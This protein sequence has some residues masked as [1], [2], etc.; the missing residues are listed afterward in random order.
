VKNNFIYKHLKIQRNILLVFLF[1][2]FSIVLFA[3]LISVNVADTRATDLMVNHTY[4]IIKRMENIGS[5][6]AESESQTRA[7]AVTGDKR[8]R[9]SLE[10]THMHVFSLLLETSELVKDSPQKKRLIEFEKLIQKKIELQKTIVSIDNIADGLAEKM[11]YNGEDRKMSLVMQSMLD[12]FMDHQDVLLQERLSASAG[13][14]NRALTTTIIGMT[15]IFSFLIVTLLRLNN[16]IRGRKK[17]EQEIRESE[18][19]YRQLIEEAGV[20][21]FTADVNGTFTYVSSRCQ[22]LTDYTS[23][24]LTGRSFTMLVVPTWVERVTNQYVQQ[25]QT[26][27]PETTIEFPIITRKGDLKWVEQHAVLLY[28]ELS[29]PAGYQC[30]VKDITGKKQA[31]ERLKESEEL[32]RTVLNNTREGFFMVNRHYEILVLNKK[33]KEDMEMITGKPAETGMNIFSFILDKERTQATR[34]FEKVFKG[35]IVDYESSFETPGGTIWIKIS[36]SPVRAS[37]GYIIGAA[38]VTH[39]ITQIK[40]NAE[41]IK[42][43]DQKIRAM[44]SSTQ[45][46]FYMISPDYSIIMINEAAQRNIRMITG[47]NCELG[48]MIT[49]FIAP[50]GRALFPA[51]F[52][53][54]MKGNIEEVDAYLQTEEGEKWF[55]NSY[56]PVRGE[57]NRVIAV[58]ASSKDITESKLAEKALGKIRAEREEY[59]FRLQSIL[60]NTPSIVFVKD[61]EGKYLVINKA[62]REIMGLADQQVIGKTDFDFDKPEEAARYQKSDKEVIRTLRSIETEETFVTPRGVQN[63]LLVKFPLFDKENNIYGVGGIATDF[64]DT[65]ENRQKLIE[66]KKKAES[67]EQLQEQFLAN[68]SHEIRTPMNGI[69]GMTNIL[70]STSLDEKQKEFVKIIKQSSDNLLVL[71]NDILDLSKIK[72]GK[73][74]LEKTSFK[75]REVLDNTLAPFYLKA[76]EKNIQLQLLQDNSLPG[77]VEGDPYRLNQILNNLLSNAM[78]FTERGSV[79]VSV[80]QVQHTDDTVLL[81]FAVSDTGIGIP[82]DKLESIFNSFEQASTSTTRQ[83]GGT[84][85]GLAISKQ[86]AEMQ[87]GNIGV[88]STI[89]AGTTFSFVI[90]YRFV[91]KENQASVISINNAPD[92]SALAGKK[93]LVAEDNEINQKV[94]FHVLGKEGIHVQLADNGREAVNL[95]EQGQ[96]YDLIIMDLQMP[97]MDG[98]QATTYIR[99]KLRCN[100]PIIAMTASVLRN[101]K[102]KCFELGM[103]EYLSKP[104]VPAELFVQLKRFLYPQSS[105]MTP[106]PVNTTQ[107]E[108]QPAGL[109]DLSYLQDM[110]DNEYLCEILQLFLDTTPVM[111]DE[112]SNEVLHENWE[113]VNKKAHKLKSNLGILKMNNML[114]LVAAIER[115]AKEKSETDK[116]EGKLKQVTEQFGLIRPMIEAELAAAM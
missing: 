75:L 44:L 70:M 40:I 73:L 29:Q 104:F 113:V 87:G 88:T 65:V 52:E 61:L 108:E 71:I 89:G 60:D 92:N 22:F 28:N 18:S 90:P 86:L 30:V 34:N 101:E 53:R 99:Q 105:S 54:V 78:K 91:E 69:T 94:I 112:L 2:T 24:E 93:I 79:R 67:A 76:K 111:L 102:V 31:E 64:T 85:L 3:K 107:P 23:A 17:A 10:K 4:D 82:A 25:L 58:C 20:T 48:D 43:A 14:R 56:F 39:D 97:V 106:K 57:G 74:S 55:H 68:M 15:L 45:E 8:W 100:T 7:Y 9:E 81:E 63:L 49:D 95:L 13:A 103:N 21:M 96:E 84:G 5:A 116:I 37:D 109:Y 32:I 47:K 16:D 36:H 42:N 110:D 77:L 12:Q 115:Q 50:E 66:A 19:K 6:V 59:Q 80:K 62:F 35:E 38:V 33:A 98:F 72:S 27:Q 26:L 1:A 51:L 41:K 11:S 83:F 46:A 114:E